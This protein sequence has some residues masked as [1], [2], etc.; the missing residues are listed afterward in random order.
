MQ[1]VVWLIGIALAAFFALD[2]IRDVKE[3]MQ[4]AH[5]EQDREL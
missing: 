4:K 5:D 3:A 1:I 2:F